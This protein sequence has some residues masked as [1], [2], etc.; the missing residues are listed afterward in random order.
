MQH[1]QSM[2]GKGEGNPEHGRRLAHEITRR[3]IS[4]S[5]LAG[6]IDRRTAEELPRS[7]ALTSKDTDALRTAADA[8]GAHGGSGE[9]V[10]RIRDMANRATPAEEVRPWRRGS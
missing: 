1:C 2:A 7:V 4:A 6:G 5:G 10:R 9:A 8:L 3:R